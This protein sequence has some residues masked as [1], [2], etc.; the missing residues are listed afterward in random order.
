VSGFDIIYATLDEDFDR[1]H[2]IHSM[3]AWLGRARA[4]RVSWALHLLGAAALVV[5][6]W[7]LM[8]SAAVRATDWGIAAGV[9]LAAA[10]LLLYL[11]QRWAEDVNL[12]FFKTNVWV[13]F[14]VLAMVLAARM[15]GGGF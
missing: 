14:V 3:V 10:F 5:T 11:E 12:A 15:A 4:L 1:G 8:S 13:G 2:G 6:A 9:M 7:L